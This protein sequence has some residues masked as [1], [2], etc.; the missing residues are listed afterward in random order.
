MALQAA[1][2]SYMLLGVCVPSLKRGASKFK[3]KRME[4]DQ[5]LNMV[6]FTRVHSP[7]GDL[8]KGN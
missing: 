8:R 4:L 2:K 3:I 7:L 1:S 5:N 6:S